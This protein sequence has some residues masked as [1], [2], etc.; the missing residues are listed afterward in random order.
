MRRNMV[1]VVV[2][3]IVSFLMPAVSLY[4]SVLGLYHDVIL[5][6]QECNITMIVLQSYSGVIVV[7]VLIVMLCLTLRWRCRPQVYV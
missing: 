2:G 7:N 1:L 4:C 3:W 6:I 5:V